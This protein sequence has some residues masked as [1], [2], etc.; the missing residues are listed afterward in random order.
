MAV[1]SRHSCVG[2]TPHAFAFAHPLLYFVECFAEPL[3]MDDFSFPQVTKRIFYARVGA[4]GN[5]IFVRDTRTLLG[6]DVGDQIG[7]RITQ[8]GD[9]DGLRRCGLSKYDGQC[10]IGADCYRADPS[11]AIRAFCHTCADSIALTEMCRRLYGT[12]CTCFVC[13]KSAQPMVI[14]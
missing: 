9:I 3:Q 6:I 8:A 5:E 4:D 2:T 14:F 13:K 1:S 7:Y 11:C 12:A 10:T